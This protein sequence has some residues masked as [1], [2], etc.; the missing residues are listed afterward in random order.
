MFRNSEPS[1]DRASA[2]AHNAAQSA[3]STGEQ[4][5]ETPLGTRSVC[6]AYDGTR[7]VHDVDASIQRGRVTV[8]IGPN[9]SGK[10]TLL[11]AM[12]GLHRAQTGRVELGGRSISDLSPRELATHLTLL[13]QNRPTPGGFTVQDVVAFGRH[14]H[15]SRFT[16]RDPHGPAAIAGALEAT[17]LTDLS[18]RPVDTLSGGQMQRV[19]LASCLAQDTDI[20]L[21][22]EP[23]NHLDLRHQ[24]ELL[25]LV[26]SLARSRHLAVGIVLH[27]LQQAAAVAD[28]IVL[29]CEGRVVATGSPREVLTADRLREVYGVDVDVSTHETTGLLRIDLLGALAHLDDNTPTAQHAATLGAA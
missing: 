23:T 25:R 28:D 11:R 27:D 15:R 7:V 2:Q 10:S 26:R 4:T 5:S 9:G 24:V 13:S 14:P 12:S 3:P 16:S 6:L 8:L 18:H 21:L 17:G 29:L 1:R 22:D 20:L 19:W